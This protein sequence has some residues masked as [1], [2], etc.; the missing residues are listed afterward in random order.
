MFS[1]ER[2][3]WPRLHDMFKA[4]DANAWQREFPVGFPVEVSA[5]YSLFINFVAILL[6]VWKAEAW[7]KQNMSCWSV[8]SF[9]FALEKL[10][11]HWNA[12]AIFPRK[13]ERINRPTRH[14]FLQSH[15]LSLLPLQVPWCLTRSRRACWMMSLV[16]SLIKLAKRNCG[17]HHSNRKS[18]DYVYGTKENAKV[19]GKKKSLFETWK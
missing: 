15:I 5:L 12:R 7:L 11:S 9:D 2:A 14:V 19:H 8:N 16:V 13:I 18:L 10:H 6:L 17:W 4:R 3:D 1:I